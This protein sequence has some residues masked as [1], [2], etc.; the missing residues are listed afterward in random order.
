MPINSKGFTL[1]ELMVVVAIIGILASVAIPA[2]SA[3]AAKSANSACLAEAKGYTM[4]LLAELNNSQPVPSV[5]NGGACFNYQGHTGM[6]TSTL[7]VI[8][9]RPVS[10]G[11]G[12][13][14]CDLSAGNPCQSNP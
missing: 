12:N 1:I 6:T 8:T 3:Y 9:A 13:V 10:P 14:S 2:Y 7:G 5:P 4:H 11:T